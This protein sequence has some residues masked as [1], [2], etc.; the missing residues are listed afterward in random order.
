MLMFVGANFVFAQDLGM[1]H[2]G[3]LGLIDNGSQD[4]RVLIINVLRYALTFVGIIAVIII[5]YG[6]WL[7]MTSKGDADQINKAKKT[8]INA[9]IGLVIILSAFII[10]SFIANKV[11]DGLSG[12][13]PDAIASCGC[14]GQK[15]CG[16]DGVWGDCSIVCNYTG[17]E[18]CCPGNICDTDCGSISAFA[19]ESTVPADGSLNI[20]RNAKIRFYFN[21]SVD[22][23]S[24]A[25][26]STFNVSGN[27]SGVINGTTTVSGS[28]IAFVPDSPC[29]SNPCDANNCLPSNE[30]ITIEVIGESS[31]GILSV[32]GTQLDCSGT[33]PCQI[34]FSTSDIIDCEKPNILIQ[35]DTQQCLGYDNDLGFTT[36]DDSGVAQVQFSDSNDNLAFIGDTLIPCPGPGNCGNPTDWVEP[37]GTAT[38][39]PT[40]PAYITGENYTIYAN[41][42]DLDN[43]SAT[44]TKNFIL[45]PEHCCNNIFDEADGEEGIDCGGDCSACDGAACGI[46]LNES[47]GADNVNC[48]DNRCSS[49]FCN[50]GNYGNDICSTKGYDIT[51][52]ECCI[53]EG[54][55]IIDWITPIG[56]FCDDDNNVFCDDDSDCGTTCDID[57]ANGAIGNL[58]TIGGRNFEETAGQ[59]EF[60]NG[61]GGWITANLAVTVNPQCNMS[62]TDT[63]IIVV[64]PNGTESTPVVRVTANSGFL[65]TTD[66]DLGSIVE[67]ILNTIDRPGICKLNPDNGIMNDLIDYH[68]INLPNISTGNVYFGNGNISDSILASEYNYTSNLQVSANLPNLEE[69]LTSTFIADNGVVGNTLDFTKNSEPY[70][71]PYIISF[72]ATTGNIGQYITIKGVGFGNNKGLSKVYFDQDADIVN[73]LDGAEAD[74]N[75][76]E[77]CSDSVWKDNQ[78]IVKVPNLLNNGGYYIVIDLESQVESIDTF[79]LNPSQFIF[80]DSLPLSPSLCKISPIMGPNN[81]SINLWGEYFGAE[82]SGLVRFFQSQ[83]Q[84]IFTFWGDEDDANKIETNVHQDAETGPVAVVQSGLEGNGID[85]RIGMCTEADDPDNACGLD[86]CCPIGTYEEGRCKNTIDDCYIDIPSSVY[87]WDFSTGL[88][89]GTNI[90]DPCDDNVLAPSCQASSTMC[91]LPL[92]CNSDSCIC[93]LP[94]LESCSGYN[95]LQCADAEFCPNSP[96]QCSP[97][98]GENVQD[99]GSCNDSD[100]DS[101]CGVGVCAY[102]NSLNRCVNGNICDLPD[103]EI[104]DVL[105]NTINAYCTDYNGSARWHINTQSSCPQNPPNTHSW[106]SIGNN[107]CIED[108][109]TCD[110]CSNN[111]SCLNNSGSG[112]CGIDNAVC[113]LGSSCN[114]GVC[115]KNDNESCEC[116]CEIGYD[117]RDCCSPLICEY[118]CGTDRISD[119]DTYGYCSGCANAGTTQADHDNACNCEGHSGKFCE[120]TD[121]NYPEGICRDCEQLSTSGECTNHDSVCCVDAMKSDICRGGTGDTNLDIPANNIGYCSYYD[122]DISDPTLC[123]NNANFTGVYDNISICT[124]ECLNNNVFGL[125]GKCTYSSD[126][127][128]TINENTCNYDICSSPWDCLSDTGI[129]DP[130]YPD[131]GICCCTPGVADQCDLDTGLTTLECQADQSPCSGSN[132]GLCCGCDGD[133]SCG[134]QNTIGCGSDTCCRTRPNVVIPTVPDDESDNICR[135]ALITAEFSQLM[136]SNSFTGNVIIVGDYEFEQ[137]PEGTTYLALNGEKA[138]YKNIIV[139]TFYKTTEIISKILYRVL[140]SHT[141]KAYETIVENHNYCAIEGTV[142][143]SINTIGDASIMEFSPNNL[144][145]TDQLYYVIIKGDENLDSSTGVKSIWGIGM[146]GGNTETFNGITY[147]NSY[148]WSFTTLL[149]QADNNGICE[150][151]NVKIDP[152]SYLFQTTQDDANENDNNSGDITFDTVRDADKVFEANAY[153]SDEQILTS[154]TGYEWE[155]IW[156]INPEGVA[157]IQTG[158]FGANDNKQLIQVDNTITEGKTKVI[159]EVNLIDNTYSSIGDGITGIADIYVFVCDNPWP[160]IALDGTWLPWSDSP[161][162]CTITGSGCSDMNYEM[163][164]CRDAGQTGTYDDLPAI[165]SGDGNTIIRGASPDILKEAYYFRESSPTAITSLVLSDVGVGNII[166]TQWERA[167][168]PNIDGYK[169]YFGKNSE[170]YDDFVEILN[171]SNDDHDDIDCSLIGNTINCDVSNLDNNITYYFN[172]TSYYNTGTESSYYGEENMR[173][174][175]STNPDAPNNFIATAENQEVHLTWDAVNDA[176]SYKIYY[177]TE[178][179]IYGHSENIGVDTEVVVAGLINGHTYYFAVTAIDGSENE[180]LK[181]IEQTVTLNE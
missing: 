105:G 165:L 51:G 107:M 80:D 102:N 50:C 181:A 56:G 24:V 106:I 118:D 71:G 108:G 156:D 92:E 133:D 137:C 119:T 157:N 116:C 65:D 126:S 141:A 11:N 41:A 98:S 83:D 20:I 135:N 68:G 127:P 62:W 75:F 121:L 158:L 117:A 115:E 150:I 94:N 103:Y 179:G 125:G 171:N 25:V 97:Y 15:I 32:Y 37:I 142:D 173:A 70:S 73:N 174:T 124:E 154:I 29:P 170:N 88:E 155:W 96:G 58:I 10:V 63:Q 53:C 99:V 17:G 160:P 16:L 136:D 159:V 152:L 90:G 76:P 48:D 138:K 163:Y 60:S 128:Q 177:G 86:I 112:V 42:E 114:A 180:S 49:G 44:A 3:N 143:S 12:C 23:D 55:P 5:M 89:G 176:S 100:C 4:I 120:T 87:E 144:L 123:N 1:N 22:E 166:N 54:A 82:T 93:E 40:E 91:V 169:L 130:L 81:S 30:D 78:I 148:I 77:V 110:L 145:D 6:G 131:C 175:D 149:E 146:N 168:D 132:R 69:G 28:R 129:T 66:D 139:K 7:W 34:T 67:F 113:P 164:Y 172:L 18:K 45:R 134:N 31:I 111:F 27:I 21:Q 109:T 64:I 147:Q 122:C 79:D 39:N 153:S 178:S 26:N 38:W 101:E 52:D 104:Q 8:L 151:D 61:V 35:S 19:I 46:N 43:N 85:F 74:Y 59:V 47:C 161:S 72:T 162:N 9:T 57:I 95:M 13:E 140:P 36:S 2:A 84:N 167:L 14:G 33:V